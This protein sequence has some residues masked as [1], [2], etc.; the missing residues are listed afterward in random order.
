MYKVGC[1][2][3][4][5]EVENTH[6]VQK[7]TFDSFLGKWQYTTRNCFLSENHSEIYWEEKINV[8]FYTVME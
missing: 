7:L 5:G 8:Y 4:K 3:G 6:L 2:S 1:D